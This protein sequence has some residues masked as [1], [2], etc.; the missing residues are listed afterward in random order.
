MTDAAQYTSQ[1]RMAER[2]GVLVLFSLANTKQGSGIPASDM[3][4]RRGD[5]MNE[6]HLLSPRR[7]HLPP[8]IIC[9]TPYE[10]ASPE[11]PRSLGISAKFSA[12]FSELF[13][14]IPMAENA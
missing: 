8:T 2:L 9:P 11:W 12:G 4:S 14:P 3:S 1:M 7:H 13:Y 10:H 6:H 5:R